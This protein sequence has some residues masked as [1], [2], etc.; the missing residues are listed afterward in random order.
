LSLIFKE[1]AWN[2][3]RL[4]VPCSWEAGRIGSRHLMLEDETGPVME[5]KWGWVKGG[6]SPLAQLKRLAA[7]HTRQ[8]SGGL[9]EWPVPPH[10]QKALAPFEVT[11]F[12][13]SSERDSGR[14]VILFCPSCRKASILQFFRQD[15][16]ASE[17][18]W[19][20]ILASYRDHRT[21]GRIFWSIFDIRAILPDRLHLLKYTFDA[22]RFIIEFGDGQQNVHL[23]RWAPAAALLGGRDLIHFT[24]TIP[25]LAQTDPHP[26]AIDGDHAVEWSASPRGLWRRRVSRLRMKPSFFWL[27]LWHLEAQNRI[28]SIWARSKRP[29]DTLLLDQI[30]RDYE[31]I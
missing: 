4:L 25:E 5:L 8:V 27:R 22:G 30:A 10:W 31:S 29:L 3:I 9:R 13:W 28:L 20:E 21:D 26:L 12:Q 2:G 6:F 17:H 11:G 23:Y 24:R 16:P 15:D 19:R 14:G 1:V 7:V 18:I